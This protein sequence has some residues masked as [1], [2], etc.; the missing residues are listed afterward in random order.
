M[1]RLVVPLFRPP[2]ALV[3][4]VARFDVADFER[5]V[6]FFAVP[7]FERA[8]DEVL[9]FF[10]VF[11]V[12]EDFAFGTFPPARRA[13]ERPMAI[14]CLRLVTFF[15]LPPLFSVP[16]FRSCIAFSTFSCA[17]FP[18]FAIRSP[19]LQCFEVAAS[20]FR[21]AKSRFATFQNDLT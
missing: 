18:Y 4:G 11:V 2:E 15:P 7:D 12:D 16:A 9:F 20:K 6:D 10:V 14:A 19:P 13:S 21:A 8:D 3:R 17:F 5:E 1:L